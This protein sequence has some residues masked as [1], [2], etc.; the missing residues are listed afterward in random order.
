MHAVVNQVHLQP[1]K[2]DEGL[3]I[4]RERIV[5]GLKQQRGFKGLTLLLSREQN[6]GMSV[7]LWQSE[8][9]AQAAM[10]TGNFAAKMQEMLQPVLAGPPDRSRYEVIIHEDL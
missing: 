1:G 9:D 10:E 6:R 7:L 3:G 4:W 8:T 2:A 5:P